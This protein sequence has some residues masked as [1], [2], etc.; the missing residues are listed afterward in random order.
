MFG[1]KEQQQHTTNNFNTTAMNQRKISQI[2]HEYNRQLLRDAMGLDDVVYNQM[3][4]RYGVKW[5]KRFLLN[6]AGA[7]Y[8]VSKSVAFWAW[9]KNQFSLLDERFIYEAN[10]ERIEK[11]LTGTYLIV[12]RD[13]Y[14]ELHNP[15]DL[16]ATPNAFVMKEIR[17]GL[18]EFLAIE[19]ER[20]KA[21][22]KHGKRGN[23]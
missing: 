15:D 3:V 4:W 22:I 5:I 21:M 2:K 1:K 12:A 19:T 14:M 16:Q 9:W 6:D 18:R 13:L 11:P 10:I 7:E 23:T 8:A 20:L 17:D